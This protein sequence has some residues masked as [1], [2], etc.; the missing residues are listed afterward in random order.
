[1]SSLRTCSRVPSRGGQ[2]VLSTVDRTMKALGMRDGIAE[3][4]VSNSL[5]NGGRELGRS[6]RMLTLKAG[7]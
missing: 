2:L 4:H 3:M 7:K 1:M 6:A 5:E